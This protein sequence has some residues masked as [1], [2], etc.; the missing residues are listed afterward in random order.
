MMT[1]DRGQ[2]TE[3][4]RQKTE[5]RGQRTEER[6]QRT[7]VRRQKREREEKL[8]TANKHFSW[9][10]FCLNIRVVYCMSVLWEAF[11]WKRC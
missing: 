6:R 7:E 4:R 1:E 2:K 5:D 3:D 11:F 9:Y 8:D 10:S